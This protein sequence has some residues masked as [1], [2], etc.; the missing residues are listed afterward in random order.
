MLERALAPSEIDFSRRAN[1][2]AGA[3]PPPP[4]CAAEA[5]A[6]KTSVGSQANLLAAEII[7]QI[8]HASKV[9]PP[10]VKGAGGRAHCAAAP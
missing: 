8:L 1:A 9:R 2:A 5:G 4:C 10:R 3:S 7:E 6:A